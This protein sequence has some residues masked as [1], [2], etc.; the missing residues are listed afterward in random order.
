MMNNRK[1]ESIVK[2]IERVSI[3]SILSIAV[4]IFSLVLVFI[5]HLTLTNYL[6]SEDYGLYYFIASLVMILSILTKGGIDTLLIK[7]L[8]KYSIEN[9]PRLIKGLLSFTNR[10]VIINCIIIGLIFIISI[11]AINNYK[12][13]DNF[14]DYLY[15]LI[16]L[17]CISFLH[18]NQA[19]LIGFKLPIKSQISE[20]LIFPIIFLVSISYL[21]HSEGLM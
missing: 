18:I 1:N 8:P 3:S 17:P 4:N 2:I 6:G 10:R 7:F 21:L 16:L 20:K 19:K 11:F 13:L 12:H 9:N 15:F 5:I 14:N